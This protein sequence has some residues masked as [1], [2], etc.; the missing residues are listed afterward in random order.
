MK[1]VVLLVAVLM[2][3]MC[4]SQIPG[5]VVSD[6]KTDTGPK[7]LPLPENYTR[8]GWCRGLN[9]SIITPEENM[10]INGGFHIEWT[11]VSKAEFNYANRG[12]SFSVR[13]VDENRTVLFIKNMTG[14][15]GETFREDI[16][17]L[18][19]FGSGRYLVT[20]FGNMTGCKINGD[21]VILNVI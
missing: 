6:N 12:V 10:T 1:Y 9:T 5:G 21:S 19:K 3:T 13:M 16:T 15:Y 8:S 4:T 18:E 17:F 14:V 7:I 20:V 11:L 2:V